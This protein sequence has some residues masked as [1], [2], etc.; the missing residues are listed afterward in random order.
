MYSQTEQKIL[1]HTIKKVKDLFE[2]YPSKGH[3]F[4]HAEA[5]AKWAKEIAIKE[6]AQ[7]IFLCEL[8]G[9]LHDVGRAAESHNIGYKVESDERGHHELS[10]LMLRDW[11]KDDVMFKEL[12]SDQQIELLYSIRNHWNNMADEYDT[13]WILRDAD[14]L[15]LFG[16]RGIQRN[17]ESHGDNQANFNRAFRYIYDCYYWMKTKSARQIIEDQKLMDPINSY[18]KKFLKERIKPVE[19]DQN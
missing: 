3:N 11:F 13:A 9:Y 14:K 18:Y 6:K 16:E 19:T 7:D 17:E 12:S 2:K 10:Y 1:D 8:A 5:T 15:D 4:D